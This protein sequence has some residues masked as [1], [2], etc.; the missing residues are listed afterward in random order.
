MFRRVDYLQDRSTRCHNPENHNRN[1]HRRK[2]Y[3]TFIFPH[4]IFPQ[5]SVCSTSDALLYCRYSTYANMVSHSSLIYKHLVAGLCQQVNTCTPPVY[6]H[7]VVL[8]HWN[9]TKCGS[10]TVSRS[11]CR[12]EWCTVSVRTYIL[13]CYDP[14]LPNPFQFIIHKHP[15][16]Y[17][18]L[19]LE[20]PMNK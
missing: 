19:V 17:N 20:V 1:I 6:L 4:T 18:Q 11:E 9:C 7:V 8:G 13:T 5:I 2:N 10:G 15:F 12:N 3:S 14:F 16:T